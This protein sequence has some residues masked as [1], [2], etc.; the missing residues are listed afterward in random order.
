LEAVIFDFDGLI[1]DTER[2]EF[3]S[4][5]AVY[6]EFG[7]ELAFADWSV[8]IGT[9]NAFDP[10]S[11][12]E[13]L[14]GRRHDREAVRARV[15]EKDRKMLDEMELLPGV[16]D[17]LDEADAM[18]VKVGLA[19]SSTDQWVRGNLAEHGI[20]GRFQAIR[21]RT[22]V[23]RAKPFPDL[24]LAAAEALGA[25][26]ER[27]IALEDSMNGV[28]SAKEAGMFCIAVPNSLTCQLDLSAADLQV[29]SL[30]DFTFAG[31]SQLP[32]RVK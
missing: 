26:P 27:C 11:H 19:S 5:C 3:D 13:K 20:L 18:G 28:R 31:L 6:R 17:R 16:L 15:L 14:T 29:A 21:T 1:L 12:L 10:V 23:A 30:R 25:A 8:C 22:Q 24:F 32:E 2:A 9:T 7:A 4:W